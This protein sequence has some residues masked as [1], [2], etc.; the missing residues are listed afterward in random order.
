M[1]EYGQHEMEYEKNKSY[2]SGYRESWHDALQNAK[3]ILSNRV[4]EIENSQKEKTNE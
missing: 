1:S 3:K 2:K 4:K